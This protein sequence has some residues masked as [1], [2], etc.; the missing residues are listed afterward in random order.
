MYLADKRIVQALYGKL[1]KSFIMK[2]GFPYLVNLSKNNLKKEFIN[3]IS[4][5]HYRQNSSKTITIRVGR[6]SM[7]CDSVVENTIATMKRIVQKVPQ[8]WSNIQV[9]HIK[10]THSV[11]L[12]IFNSLTLK[13]TKLPN[14]M[15]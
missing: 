12:P 1:G 9:L 11:A 2:R 14:F 10:T 4:S 15:Q 6:L 13:A 3:V 8:G 5:T 7:S